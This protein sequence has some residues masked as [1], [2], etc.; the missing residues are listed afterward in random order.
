MA[1]PALA[2]L[3]EPIVIAE[4]DADKFSRL[5]TK[6]DIDGFPTLKIFMHGVPMDYN[7]PRKADLLVRYLKKFVAPEVSILDSDSAIISNFVEA[8]GTYFPIYIG[9]GL[10]E[11][12]I[13]DMAKK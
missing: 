13:S 3:K 4:V 5:A 8:A 2:A 9:F 10:N 1:A 6:F 7:G 12:V 11:S